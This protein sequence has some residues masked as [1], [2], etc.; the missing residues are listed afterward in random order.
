LSVQ[1]IQNYYGRNATPRPVFFDA[2]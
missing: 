2:V 1:V